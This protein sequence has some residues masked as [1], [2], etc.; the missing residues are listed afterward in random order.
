LQGYPSGS[1]ISLNPSSPS[2]PYFLFPPPSSA[3]KLYLKKYRKIV[4]NKSPCKFNNRFVCFS[5]SVTFSRWKLVPLWTFHSF[6]YEKRFAPV[7]L[8]DEK[9]Q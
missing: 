6:Y 3:Q 2:P 7:W 4:K 1:D 8:R 5:N 9:Y